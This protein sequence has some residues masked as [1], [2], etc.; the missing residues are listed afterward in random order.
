LANFSQAITTQ[1]IAEALL[2]PPRRRSETV[3]DEYRAL[4]HAE[5]MRTN[6]H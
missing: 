3:P 4:W 6:V 5:E 2:V 1:A